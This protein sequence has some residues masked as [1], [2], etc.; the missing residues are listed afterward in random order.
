MSSRHLTQANKFD[1]DEIT[2]ESGLVPKWGLELWVDTVVIADLYDCE[3]QSYP[4]NYLHLDNS[5]PKNRS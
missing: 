2:P 4:W 5:N 3:F 1:F